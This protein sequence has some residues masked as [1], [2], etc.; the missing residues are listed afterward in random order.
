MKTIHFLI[1]TGTSDKKWFPNKGATGVQK[2][3]F[4]LH[5]SSASGIRKLIS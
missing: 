1:V 5:F 4:T 3:Q 2:I